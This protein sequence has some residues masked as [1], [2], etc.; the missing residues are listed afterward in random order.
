[1]ILLVVIRQQFAFANHNFDVVII[2]LLL[3]LKMEL[4]RERKVIPQHI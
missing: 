4:Y 3:F 2:S 1:M